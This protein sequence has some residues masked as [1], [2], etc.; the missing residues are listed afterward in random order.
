MTTTL[1]WTCLAWQTTFFLRFTEAHPECSVRQRAFERLKPWWV[2]KLKE[3]NTC[4]CIY[5]VQMDFM[6]VALGLLRDKQ[7]GVHSSSSCTCECS[8]C[9]G[10]IPGACHAHEAIFKRITLMWESCVCPKGEL[11]VWHKLECLMGE[12]PNCGFELF[13]LCPLELSGTNSFIVKGKCFE[14]YEVGID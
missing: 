8:V 11:D 6:K 9:K 14:Y 3:R 7:R 13:A 1:L 10:E 12:C 4:C 2:R 5:H